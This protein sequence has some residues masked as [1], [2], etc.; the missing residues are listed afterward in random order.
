M[1]L[2][3]GGT[4]EGRKAAAVCEEAGTPFYYSTKGNQLIR[5]ANGMHITGGMD[6]N[7]ILSFCRENDIRLIVDAAHPFAEALH[8]N[9]AIASQQAGIPAI[10]YERNYPQRN[11]DF[12]WFDSYNEVITHLEKNNINNLLVLTGVN[13]VSK[14]K[15]YWTKRACWFRILNREE[16]REII[17]HERFPADKVLYYQEK[18]DDISLF[19]QLNPEAILIKESGDSGGFNEKVE[20]AQ[21]LGIPVLVIK[22]PLLSLSFIPVYGENGLRKQIEQQLPIFFPLRTGY[23]TGTCATAATKAALIALLTDEEQTTIDIALPSGEPVSLPVFSTT[24]EGDKVSC[25][26]LKDAGDDPDVTNGHEII[27]TVQLNANHKEVRFL[28]GIGVGIVTLPGLGLTIGEP[29]I[30]A[31]PRQMIMREVVD[32]L[33]YYQEELPRQDSNIGVDVTI[34]VPKGEEIAQKT[35]NPKLGIT[36]GISIIGTSGIVKPFS[37]D[38]FIA[39][40]R[41]EMQVAKALGCEHIVINSG[42]KSER[43]IKRQYPGLPPQAFIHY[44]NFIGETI[45]IASELG[46][47]QLILGIMI[48]K[49]VKL[50]EGHLDTHSK[51]ME[52]NKGFL[53]KIAREAGCSE[54]TLNVIQEMTMARQ[55]WDIIS[56]MEHSFFFQIIERCYDVCK[57]L[58]PDKILEILLINDEGKIFS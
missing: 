21:S 49:A 54:E 35:F 56:Q 10:R 42:A 12:L 45:K 30:N 14:L 6:E 37:S 16:S 44:G 23:T 8:T 31:T 27:S 17:K 52:M 11:K 28:Q 57:P 46:F 36:G 13:T 3:L 29:A 9:I 40:I 38:A 4:T 20:A 48:G 25:S 53:I 22:R 2:I 51:K 58:F 55:L 33:Q 5:L 18:G 43:F 41:R 32:T 1:I 34:S 39:S 47:K 19:K 24:F 7:R 15:P 26:I 50:A